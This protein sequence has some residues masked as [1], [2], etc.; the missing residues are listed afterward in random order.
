MA[1]SAFWHDLA[2]EFQRLHESY[3]ALAYERRYAVDSGVVWKFAG[4]AYG[5]IRSQFEALAGHGASEIPNAASDLLIVWLEALWD[6]GYGLQ[7]GET[8]IISYVCEAS[9]N[10]CR[11]LESRA[12]QTEFDE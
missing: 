2:V 7:S 6:D 3:G 1:N 10:F 5:S 8:G 9:A 12:V 11:T 4:S